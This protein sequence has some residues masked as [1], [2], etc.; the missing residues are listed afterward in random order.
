MQTLLQEA[1]KLDREVVC[2]GGSS[3]GFQRGA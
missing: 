2:R 3:Q 1:S